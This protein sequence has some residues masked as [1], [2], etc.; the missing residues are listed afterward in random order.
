MAEII[1]DVDGRNGRVFIEKEKVYRSEHAFS[2]RDEDIKLFSAKLNIPYEQIIKIFA[3]ATL[4]QH[5]RDQQRHIFVTE[6]DKLLTYY[7]G[8]ITPFLSFEPHSVLSSGEAAL[9]I[10]L[11]CKQRGAYFIAPFY[12]VNEGGWYFYS[13][14]TKIPALQLPWSIVVKGERAGIKNRDELISLLQSLHDRVVEMLVAFDEIARRYF[15]GANSDTLAF[16]TYHF[17]YWVTL[18]TGVLDSLALTALRRYD[19]QFSRR[20]I[21]LR[22]DINEEFLNR[23]K[24]KNQDIHRFIINNQQIINL[25][26][27]SGPRDSII[28]RERL[29][30]VQFLNKHERFNLNMFEV[31]QGFFSKVV[32]I[33]GEPGVSLQSWGHYKSHGSYFIEPYRFVESASSML[34]NFVNQYLKAMNFRAY[35]DANPELKERVLQRSKDSKTLFSHDKTL[36]IFMNGRLGF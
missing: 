2:Y 19:I 20:R 17:N 9:F 6:N 4:Q 34:F 23:L 29:R 35:L 22:K 28:H 32:N 11:F 21:G 18:Y 12:K 30:G 36:E 1:P 10:D 3:F 14:K 13:M 15:V 24:K 5:R 16:S 31:K 7:G 27:G 33:S 26:Y 8:E 25:L